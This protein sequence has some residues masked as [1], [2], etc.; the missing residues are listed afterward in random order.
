MR[1][2]N[3]VMT[4]PRLLDG[5]PDGRTAGAG[6]ITEVTPRAPGRRRGGR[7]VW[8]AAV[9]VL[10]AISSLA[11]APALRTAGVGPPVQAQ[12]QLPALYVLLAPLC[13]VLDTMSLLSV[14]QHVALL[15]TVIVGRTL[16]CSSRGLGRGCL[17]PR[18]R[19]QRTMAELVAGSVILTILAGVYTVG[20]LVPR[21]MAAI[22]LADPDA[23][24]VDFHSHTN[25]S[26]DGR[27][28]F[29]AVRSMD[30]HRDAGFDAFYVSDH[31]T[32]SGYEAASIHNPARAGGGAVA[33]PAVELL[34][35]GQH[36]VILGAAG[37]DASDCSATS[38]P[39]HRPDPAMQL[40]PD[41]PP[42][43]VL[44]VPAR[45]PL[46]YPLP[47]IGAIEIADAA[48]RA[49]DEM[50]RDEAL[51][52]A[53]ADSAGLARVASSN[54]HGWGRTAAAWTVLVIPGWRSLTPAMLDGAIRRELSGG[55]RSRITVVERRR[56]DPPAAGAMLAATVPMVTWEMLTTLT[57][58][59]RVSWLIWTWA[60]W[61]ALRHAA[62]RG[63]RQAVRRGLTRRPAARREARRKVAPSADGMAAPTASPQRGPAVHRARTSVAVSMAGSGR[64]TPRPG[65]APVMQDP[66]LG[67]PL[68]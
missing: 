46:P 52:R 24:T 41:W 28:S 42:L 8:P 14:R 48:P 53:L 62:R 21:P 11:A 10:V 19:G 58:A 27:R 65:A 9:S 26:W 60:T 2:N 1:R 7:P 13:G 49:L 55:V 38:P 59:E 45:L 61:A 20:G 22:R 37:S 33:L 5:G 51:I 34:C 64:V 18:T 47:H 39:P 36:L 4:Q 3:S 32:L 54:N 6:H 44:T 50:T 67:R 15:A 30:W 68:E 57:P 29:T 31:G 66:E 43:V 56:V 23:L 35:S 63:G 12:L 17:P 40:R 25:A 16:W